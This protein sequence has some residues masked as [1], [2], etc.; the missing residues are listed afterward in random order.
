MQQLPKWKSFA[1]ELAA[2]RSK[3]SGGMQAQPP[4]IWTEIVEVVS[5]AGKLICE[6]AKTF[7]EKQLTTLIRDLVAA[8][9][10]SQ[11]PTDPPHARLQMTLQTLQEK[12]NKFYLPTPEPFH[13]DIFGA[14]QPEAFADVLEQGRLARGYV[15]EAS[16]WLM[17][18][19]DKSGGN[20]IGVLDQASALLSEISRDEWSSQ[21]RVSVK[22]CEG[23]WGALMMQAEV[24]V[25]SLIKEF[26]N[27]S[28][29]IP[30]HTEP[31]Q[32]F[33]ATPARV[34]YVL[35]L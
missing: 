10:I 17:C 2:I 26:P 16:Q 33:T 3:A 23:E 19:F 20:Q 11:T 21:G 22:M 5:A 12:C 25:K 6:Y 14:A 27:P 31:S 30:S 9:A 4:Q 13:L 34:R 1:K 24:V 7:M 32:S 15:A 18:K 28:Q 29:L 8:F 35:C